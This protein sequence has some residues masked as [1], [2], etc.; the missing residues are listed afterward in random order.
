MNKELLKMVIPEAT[1]EEIRAACRAKKD[2]LGFD[3]EKAMF[4]HHPFNDEPLKNISLEDAMILAREFGTVR[5]LVRD[6]VEDLVEGLVSVSVRDLVWG[7]VWS[8]VRDLV[9]GLVRDLWRDLVL[10]LVW[11]YIASIFFSIEQWEM[12]GQESGVNPFQSGID[13]WESGYI[14][15]YHAKK[16]QLYTKGGLVWEG[17]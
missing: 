12:V 3:I 8:L 7:L 10:D 5:A 16:I 6:L 11:A 17:E 1:E 15:V 9:R 2:E 14:P 4:P 13:L